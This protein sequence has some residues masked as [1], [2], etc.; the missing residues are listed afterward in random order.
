MSKRILAICACGVALA[1]SMFGQ[2]V[3]GN[4]VGTVVDP[5][6]AAVPNAKVTIKDVGKGVSYSAITNAT[7]NYAQTHLGIGTY[8]VRIEVA[9]FETFVQQNITV[10]VDAATQVNAQLKIGNVGEVVNVT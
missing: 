9:G 8:E 1:T 5:S 10:E 4:I 2:A 6:G 7:G 3:F